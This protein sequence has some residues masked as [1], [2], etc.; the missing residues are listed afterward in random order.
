MRIS[1][2]SSDVCSSDLGGAAIIIDY[3]YEGPALG[4]TL[5][6]VRGHQAANPFADPGESDLTVH[7]D[8]TTIGNMARQAGLRVF[9]PV[10][11]GT[12]LPALGI[13]ARA[14]AL[15]QKSSAR[16]AAIESARSRLT[17]AHTSGQH[18]QAK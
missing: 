1:D 7:V 11:Q 5:Q 8:F 16:A 3:G 4:D 17:S 2:W 13:D 18:F 6:A 14:T 15:A 10:G 9:G 12:W